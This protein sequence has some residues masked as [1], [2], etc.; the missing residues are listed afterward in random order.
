MLRRLTLA[1]L[2]SALPEVLRYV[3]GDIQNLS[4]GRIDASIL[5]QLLT[6]GGGAMKSLLALKQLL[7]DRRL[8][9]A[10]GAAGAGCG[11]ASRSP[12]RRRRR[13]GLRWPAPA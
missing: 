4:G 2:L 6:Q 8:T 13:A 7:D 11:N 1:L 3:A 5:R 9:R 10:P 12:T